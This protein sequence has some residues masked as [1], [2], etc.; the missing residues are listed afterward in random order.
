MDTITIIFNKTARF[1]NSF[2]VPHHCLVAHAPAML[3]L[4]KGN[5]IKINRNAGQ[6]MYPLQQL[7]L[8]EFVNINIYSHGLVM[9]V[10]ENAL[11][12]GVL[13]TKIIDAFESYLASE[14][15]VTLND[16]QVLYKL[17]LLLPECVDFPRFFRETDDMAVKIT[18]IITQTHLP[19]VEY[20]EMLLFF[21]NYDFS[22]CFPGNSDEIQNQ[23]AMMNKARD[24]IGQKVFLISPH[25]HMSYFEY[26]PVD[27]PAWKC[28]SVSI[29]KP[30]T[31]G[32]CMLATREQFDRCLHEFTAGIFQKSPNPAVTTPFPFENVVFSGGL[33]SKMISAD[34]AIGRAKQADVDLFIHAKNFTERTKIFDSILEWF[35][36]SKTANP[37]TYYAVIGSVVSIYMV[38]I[39]RKFQIIAGNSTDAYGCI[40]KFDMTHVQWIYNGQ[41]MAIPDACKA[42][43][44]RLSYI[45]NIPR[46][47]MERIIKGM[48]SGFDIAKP[49]WDMTGDIDID[50]LLNEPDRLQLKKII[51]GFHGFYYPTEYVAE[52]ENELAD[53]REHISANIEKDSNATLVTMNPLEVANNVTIGGDFETTYESTLF[54]QFNKKMLSIKRNFG[55]KR[56]P[57]RTK[58]GTLRMSTK[59]M[60]VQS[61]TAD[62]G[63]YTISFIA[64]LDFKA[65]CE[66]LDTEILNLYRQGA[67]TTKL[68][69]ADGII[70]FTLT[71]AQLGMHLEKGYTCL[72][73]QRGEPL[74]IEE[75]LLSGDDVKVMFTITV[76]LRWN[77]LRMIINPIK[78]IKHRLVPQATK[79]DYVEPIEDNIDLIAESTAALEYEDVL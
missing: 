16:H 11:S 36:T 37:R 31:V 30:I 51:R 6:Y 23:I 8:G 14:Q 32:Q 61:V 64:P 24:S 19:S 70:R 39:D 55:N 9:D 41:L 18:D 27:V 56:F 35:D 26:T 12:I 2:G 47:K 76:S 71:R 78:F 3:D 20:I 75:D 40:S 52:T 15:Y 60:K 7:L 4:I 46:L 63:N 21:K 28:E 29:Q 38:G 34:S 54:T 74:N 48:Y 17:H 65:F 43:R 79:L 69:G 77:D 73:S 22:R 42:L 10:V 25:A 45:R 50:I 58:F 72:Q 13:R 33:L 5:K 67:P 44:E 1:M 59:L 49:D 68:I 62:E 57:L 53:M 66:L